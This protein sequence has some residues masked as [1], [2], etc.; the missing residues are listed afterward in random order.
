MDRAQNPNDSQIRFTR[1][2]PGGESE[3][4]QQMKTTNYRGM[5]PE[6]GSKVAAGDIAKMIDHSLLKPELTRQEVEEGCRIARE[7]G[8]ASV[9]VKPC[10][11]E[12]AAEILKGTGVLVTTVIGFPH[13]HHLTEIKVLEA[14]AAI[15][16][17][18]REI[19]VVLN[20][21]RLKSRDYCF[22]EEDIR[23]VTDAAHRSGAL[24]KV[25]LENFYLTDKEKI[26]ACRICEHAGADFVKTS[27]GFAGGGTTAGGGATIHDL[28]LMRETCS[29]KVRVKAAGGV[30]TLDAALAVRA[31]GAARIGAT[32]T[33]AIMDAARAR[34]RE[35]T[36]TIPDS[37]GELSEGY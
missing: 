30:R 33:R 4:K 18:C 27:T 20:I 5:I 16:Q 10:D 21:G 32:A 2:A 8:C 11:V 26:T 19:D 6:P 24:V 34:E 29:E 15:R 7:Y 35:G 12:I 14:E 17:G 28:R 37:V 36:L 22:V 25:I 13:G 9:C 3:V 23:A 31:V 1:K